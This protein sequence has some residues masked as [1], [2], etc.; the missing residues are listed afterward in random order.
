LPT[1]TP[2]QTNNHSIPPC[3]ALTAQQKPTPANKLVPCPAKHH[4]ETSISLGAFSQLTIDRSG[5]M[6]GFAMQ[7]TAPSAGAL[8]TFRQTFSPW[9]GYSVNLGYS[10]VSEQYRSDSGYYGLPN[11]LNIN[12]NMYE[13][14]V[15]YI[16]HTSANKR[17]SIFGDVF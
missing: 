8:G 9:L 1:L 11:Q 13:T 17:I 5:E 14:S 10:R 2:A 16:A 12:S 3:G 6:Y 4:T 15:T 7:G